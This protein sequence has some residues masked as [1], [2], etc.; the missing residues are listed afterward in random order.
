[1]EQ[2]FKK[3]EFRELTV[4]L[5]KEKFLESIGLYHVL[6]ISMYILEKD[7]GQKRE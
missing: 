5:A 4:E 1:M 6:F 7:A 3:P 2:H